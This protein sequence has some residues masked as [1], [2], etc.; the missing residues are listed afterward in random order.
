[1]K[2][3]FLLGATG[4]IGKSALEVIEANAQDFTLMG[5][6][7]NK[8]HRAAKEIINTHNPKFI[9]SQSKESKQKG[10][11]EA[12]KL[13]KRYISSEKVDVVISG[14]SGFAGLDSTFQAVKS[15]KTVLLANKESI[16]AGGDILL[17]L[18]AKTGAKIIP[19]D[20]EHNAINQCIN[21]SQKNLR[22]INKITITA[23]GGPFIGRRLE[24]LRKAKLQDALQH[25]TWDMGAKITIDSATLINKCLEI[26]E[27]AYLF[28]LKSSQ[29][30]VVVHPQSIVHSMVTYKDGSTIAQLSNP[31]MTVPIANALGMGAL[32]KRV[33]ISFDELFKQNTQL[34]FKT[35]PKDRREYF[36]LAYKVIDQ[37]GNAGVVFNAANEIAVQAF[38]DGQLK[39]L[40]IYEVLKR[41]FNAIPWSKITDMKDI[42]HFDNYAR[43]YASKVV[44]SLT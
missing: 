25:P 16:V 29:I 28:N 44:K 6:A 40:D 32:K 7:Y 10:K 9:F 20:S 11:G 23:S 36:D 42:F 26:I 1:M 3:I 15:G 12:N 31:S 19:I 37:R 34:N 38:I 18:A 17:P 14:I 39:F 30:D 8:N 43:K 22:E 21:Y 27:A 5:F 2:N 41:T 24:D 4:S 35:L 33:E 13:L